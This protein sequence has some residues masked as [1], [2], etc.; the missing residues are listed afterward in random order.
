MKKFFVLVCSLIILVA[1]LVLPIY[2]SVYDYPLAAPDGQGGI[3]LREDH[4]ERIQQFLQPGEEV[5]GVLIPCDANTFAWNDHFDDMFW[6]RKVLDDLWIVRTQDASIKRSRGYGVYQ[7]EL[8]EISND[9]V[10]ACIVDLVKS[11]ERVLIK[12][13]SAATQMPAMFVFYNKDDGCA[14]YFQTDTGEYVY[15]TNPENNKEY[16]FRADT[17]M[18]YA[19]WYQRGTHHLWDISA[20]DMNSPEFD[21]DAPAPSVIV[22]QVAVAVVGVVTVGGL[23]L[24]FMSYC[25]KKHR[26]HKT[27]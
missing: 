10:Y 8:V 17:F 11:P 2:A 23:I 1:L 16:L 14:V 15:A 12:T 9:A 18:K 25:R 21:L 19:N 20:Y 24:G 26:G 4:A 22:L 27:D 13:G 5:V 6:K 3:V 7:Y